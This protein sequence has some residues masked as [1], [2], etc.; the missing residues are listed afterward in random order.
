MS[1]T[2]SGLRSS[3][4][5][6]SDIVAVGRYDRIPGTDAA[7]VAFVV[8]DAHQG[9]GIGSVLLEH[10]AAIAARERGITPFRGRGAPG[11]GRDA[12]A[13][14][15][16]PATRRQRQYDDGVVHLSFPIEPTAAVD[17]R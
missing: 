10:L 16:T 13:S 11:N 12:A 9:R 17:R 4:C 5:S 14:S 3:P 1:T 7:E 6:A 8:D 15:P 2:T